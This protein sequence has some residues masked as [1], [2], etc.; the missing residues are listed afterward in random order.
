ME[1]AQANLDQELNHWDFDAV[2]D[3]ARKTWS[4]EIRNA[5]IATYGGASTLAEKTSNSIP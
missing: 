1:G 3:Q 2:K 5:G 4:N